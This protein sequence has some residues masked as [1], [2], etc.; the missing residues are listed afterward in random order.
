MRLK[1]NQVLM[2]EGIHAL[3]DRLTAS[4]PASVKFRIFVSA[5]TQLII[6][7]ENRVATSDGR[8]IRRIVRD[9]RYRGYSAAETIA[10]WPSVRRGEM[11]NLFPFQDQCDVMFNSALLYE[12]AVLKVQADRYLLEVP[13]E[14]PSA[15]VAHMLRKFLQ[16]FVPIY[17]DYVPRS[18]ILREFVGGSVFEY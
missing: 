17:P 9:R 1:E 4:V 12:P 18:S 5:L 16:L 2:I 14:H 11:R 10:N 6:D 13:R 3:N 8:L 7:P 15:A